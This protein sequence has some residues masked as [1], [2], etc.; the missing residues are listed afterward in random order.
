MKSII[1]LFILAIL[2]S[3]NFQK[4]SEQ[5][6][7]ID[8]ELLSDKENN[9]QSDLGNLI[10]TIQIGVKANKE[11]LQDFENGIVPWISIENPEAE[12]SQLIEA[13]SI[14][15]PDSEITLLIDYPLNKPAEFVL[16]SA[17]KGFTKKQLILEIS[18]KYHEIYKEEESTAVTKTLPMEKRGSLINRNETD[19]KYGVWGHDIGDLDLSTIDVYKSENGKIT[20]SLGVE[21]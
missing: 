5:K 12:I 7:D 21:S 17:G 3:C 19:G 13:E 14:I 16:K 20:I 8:T 2:T 1:T 9:S 11:Q 6:E 15:V 4:S 18:K 10:S